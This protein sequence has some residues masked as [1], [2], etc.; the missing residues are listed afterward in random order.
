MCTSRR[1]QQL[2]VNATRA[3]ERVDLYSLTLTGLLTHGARGFRSIPRTVFF[4]FN[5]QFP[6]FLFLQYNQRCVDDYTSVL[7]LFYNTHEF[8][9]S[10]YIISLII[11]QDSS[12]TVPGLAPL[13]RQL[14]FHTPF[15]S[16]TNNENA[17]LSPLTATTRN[18]SYDVC[19]ASS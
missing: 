12:M 10:S 17:V 7:I 8:T 19:D 2:V 14:S 5:S 18:Y 9:Q 11:A 15:I 1:R 3:R 6:F 13:S 16:F 4:F